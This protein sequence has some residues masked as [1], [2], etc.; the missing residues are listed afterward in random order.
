MAKR[1]LELP[2]LMALERQQQRM[3]FHGEMVL[4][5]IDDTML[6][7]IPDSSKDLIQTDQHSFSLLIDVRTGIF[8]HDVSMSYSGCGIELLR[9][10][11]MSTELVHRFQDFWN[12]NSKV[13]SSIFGMFR[14]EGKKV[15]Y[16]KYF[17]TENRFGSDIY[18]IVD[19]LK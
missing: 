5:S 7:S 13:S 16:K 10:E 9:P 4:F 2:G 3:K 18:F 8:D 11:D 19:P 17:S 14:R 15:I 1:H 12:S 6:V